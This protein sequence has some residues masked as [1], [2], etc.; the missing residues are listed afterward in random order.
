MEFSRISVFAGGERLHAE[1]TAKALDGGEFF[2]FAPRC[3]FFVGG[4]HAEFGQQSGALHG[5]LKAPQRNVKCLGFA[6]SHGGHMMVFSCWL[7]LGLGG[8]G[9]VGLGFGKVLTESEK[10]L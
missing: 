2:A 8:L 6:N 1:L 5:A 10:E 7:R 4:A 9:W 3:G